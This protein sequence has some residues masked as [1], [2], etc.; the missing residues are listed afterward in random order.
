MMLPLPLL[1]WDVDSVRFPAM[2]T[3]CTGPAF[4]GPASRHVVHQR[5]NG[6]VICSAQ[7]LARDSLSCQATA[8]TL[9]PASLAQDVVNRRPAR[10]V[11]VPLGLSQVVERERG[12][13]ADLPLHQVLHDGRG[14]ATVQ[15]TH[16]H[17]GRVGILAP[18]PVNVVVQH[19]EL[20]L[21]GGVAAPC[22]IAE[23]DPSGDD[24]LAVGQVPQDRPVRSAVTAGRPRA[25]HLLHASLQAFPLTLV[26]QDVSPVAL[27]AAA[28]RLHCEV[29]TCRRAEGGRHVIKGRREFAKPDD[30]RVALLDNTRHRLC[31]LI[32]PVHVPIQDVHLHQPLTARVCR[33]CC[34]HGS[35]SPNGYCWRSCRHRGARRRA[36]DVA[37]SAVKLLQLGLGAVTALDFRPRAPRVTTFSR[38][39]RH[40]PRG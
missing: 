30:I 22:A 2:T 13:A 21:L 24:E 14:H 26:V 17:D 33:R 39:R 37:P 8:E 9:E 16:P 36:A 31:V 5:P 7:V 11:R 12:S 6:E 18:H 15:V 29:P 4:T 20:A 27:P 32:R 19:P 40:G 1:P 23:M 10:V 28:P 3:Q 34:R 35:C 25:A 38:A